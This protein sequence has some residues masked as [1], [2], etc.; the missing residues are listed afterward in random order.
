MVEQKFLDESANWLSVY[1]AQSKQERQK[2]LDL[3]KSIGNR[4]DTQEIVMALSDAVDKKSFKGKALSAKDIQLLQRVLKFIG[5]GVS[6]GIDEAVSL[7]LRRLTDAET[8]Q[9]A[10]SRSE[11]EN[12]AE[13]WS[14][15]SGDY[16]GQVIG[17]SDQ[18]RKTHPYMSS[19]TGNFEK[20]NNESY[21]PIQENGD[22]V[23]LLKMRVEQLL[24][25]KLDSPVVL[26]DVG[27]M[28]GTSLLELAI[29]FKSE[30]E[31]GRLILVATNLGLSR[32]I[33][34]Q[35][36]KPVNGQRL[37]KNYDQLYQ[38]AGHL[39][40]FLETD[41][42]GLMDKELTLPNKEM[43]KLTK[44]AVDIIHEN[45]SISAHS[46]SLEIDLAQI[47]DLLGDQGM[48]LS[49]TN[50]PKRSSGGLGRS[51]SKSD[52]L[53]TG[54]FTVSS[55]SK[56]YMENGY[57]LQDK[58]H[59]RNVAREMMNAA[60]Q[61][62]FN[63]GF[64]TVDKVVSPDDQQ[65]HVLNYAFYMAKNSE[66]L[67]IYTEKGQEIVIRPQ[68]TQNLWSKARQFFAPLLAHSR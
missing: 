68:K 60:I 9:T 26:I 35:A 64:Y 40:H 37:P 50:D 36:S 11:T 33:I 22:A 14:F 18:A 20:I 65:T 24:Q 21:V 8:K 19:Y 38:E 61:T 28:Y 47:A 5:E 55:F 4:P 10:Q 1:P 57:D 48:L 32:E 17:E 56:A 44:G 2:L 15:Y 52:Y 67:T 7:K 46:K 16:R 45:W 53:P 59:T 3:A 51:E 13:S 58:F 66:P 12:S 31:Q 62:L 43:F 27:A 34:E 29:A 6:L 54:Y 49:R 30:V 23:Q 41:V 63:R 42:E 39:V 25:K